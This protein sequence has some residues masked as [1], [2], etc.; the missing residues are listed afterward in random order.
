M[1]WIAALMIAAVMTSACGGGSSAGDSAAPNSEA[2]AGADDGAGF[3]TPPSPLMVFFGIDGSS[4]DQV[5]MYRE[6]EQQRQDW[7]T[8]CM[9]DEGFTYRYSESTDDISF[10]APIDGEPAYGTREWIER[11]GLGVST[12]AFDQGTVGSDLAGYTT[13]TSSSSAMGEDPN[14]EYLS[15]LTESEAQA[16]YEALYGTDSGYEWDQSLS[17][18]ANQT[19]SDDYYDNDYVPSGCDALSQEVAQPQDPFFQ[20]YE[21]FGD[22]LTSIYERVQADP[23]MLAALDVLSRCMKDAGFS[24][25]DEQTT[26]EDFNQRMEPI[27]AT[28]SSAGGELTEERAASMS[29]AELEAFLNTP[30]IMTDEGKAMLAEVQA[31]EI[32]FGVALFD[33]GSSDLYPLSYAIQSRLEQEFIDTH[34]AELDAMRN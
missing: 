4:D 25:T 26:Y 18:E 19:A 24:Y 1:K 21:T 6:Q 31:D 28:V 23:E 16:Y 10:D 30:Q 9:A 15:S 32:A 14:G 17:D 5:A 20:V 13:S 3:Q 12:Q 11:Y 27:Y 34:R 7:I 29:D 22:E 33:C 8:T 2:S